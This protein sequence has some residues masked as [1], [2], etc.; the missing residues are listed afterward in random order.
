MTLN[1]RLEH[2]LRCFAHEPRS[3]QYF[4]KGELSGLSPHAARMYLDRLLDLG[5]VAPL[6]REQYMATAAGV[7]YL[8]RP[9]PE[10]ESPAATPPTVASGPQ[11]GAWS[12]P[13]GSYRPPSWNA[14]RPGA[15]AHRK[16]RSHGMGC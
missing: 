15:D 7:A 14:I 13:P 10:D 16:W 9:T 5:Y 1:A 11:Y 8:T 12:T 4:T 6:T 2:M 3:L